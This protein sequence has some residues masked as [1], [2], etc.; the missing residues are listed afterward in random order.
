MNLVN[1]DSNIRFPRFDE[2][3]LNSSSIH[4]G[5]GGGGA[6]NSSTT[7]SQPRFEQLND[8]YLRYDFFV[9]QLSMTQCGE[10]GRTERHSW[11]ERQISETYQ[12]GHYV[13]DATL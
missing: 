10:R 6:L 4:R 9:M 7:A 2:T 5:G 11:D 13:D 12:W 8:K 3:P 1:S